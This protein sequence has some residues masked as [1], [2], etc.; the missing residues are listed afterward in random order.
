MRY[1]LIFGNFQIEMSIQASVHRWFELTLA[2]LVLGEGGRVHGLGFGASLGFR[3]GEEYTLKHN[4]IPNMISLPIINY[5]NRALG[6]V[7]IA[8]VRNPEEL[9]W[10]FSRF[11]IAKF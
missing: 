11:N 5:W 10:Y 3:V 6:H 2:V 8:S 7:R 9:C 1:P 4:R